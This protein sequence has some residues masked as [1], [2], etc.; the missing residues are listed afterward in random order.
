MS[1]VSSAGETLLVIT[2]QMKNKGILL[3]DGHNRNIPTMQS[4]SSAGQPM[5]REVDELMIFCQ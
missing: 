4:L 3:G 2:V 5:Y 1:L